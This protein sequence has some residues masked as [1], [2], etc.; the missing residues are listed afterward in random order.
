[1]AGAVR[2]RLV[3]SAVASVVAIAGVAH[4]FASA[5]FD[6]VRVDL[7]NPLFPQRLVGRGGL[8]FVAS[9]FRGLLFVI[10]AGRVFDRRSL[11]LRSDL[12]VR[13]R[14]ALSRR[15]GAAVLGAR[16]DRRIGR[17]PS[18]GGTRSLHGGPAMGRG[19]VAAAAET[20]ATADSSV[21][22]A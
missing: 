12:L 11:R 19:R 20:T 6:L 17:Y 5:G 18:R 10:L 15:S 4:G 7:V 1:V 9:G 2:G 8:L 16:P 21:L 22:A 13:M 14:G 3:S